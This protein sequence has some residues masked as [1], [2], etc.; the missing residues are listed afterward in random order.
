MDSNKLCFGIDFGTTNSCISI[1]H[2]NEPI[3]IEDFEGS[4]I[5]PTVIE[6]QD[7]KKIIGKEAYNRKEIFE[8]M[9]IDTSTIYEIKKL[10]GKKFSDLKEEEI[11]LIGYSLSSDDSDKIIL[12]NKYYVEEIITH[13]FMSFKHFSNEFLSKKFKQDLNISNAIITV[14]ARFNDNQREV[15]KMCAT[16]AGFNVIRL[17]NEPTSA[18]LAYG[19]GFVNKN[20]EKKIVVFDLGGGTLDISILNIFDNNYEV[21]G[22]SGNSSLGGS[23]FDIKIME[24]CIKKFIENNKLKHEEVTENIS[25]KSLQK[26]KYLS[27]KAKISLSDNLHTKII[28][29]DFYDNLNL[30]IKLSREEFNTICKDLISLMLKPMNELLIMCELEKTD[31]DEIIMVGGMTKMPIVRQNVELFFNNKELNDSIDPD[32]VVSIGSALYG[33]M[34]ISEENIED[35]LLLIDRTSLSIGLETSGGIMDILIPRGSIIPIKKV[36][37]YTTDTDFMENITIK[38]FEGERKFTKDNF[39]IGEFVL[40]GIEKKKRGIPEIQ[41]TFFID[42]NGIIKIKAEDL[43]NTLNKKT[44]QINGNKQNLNQEQIDK[45]IESAKMMDSIDR[46]DKMKKQ[47]YHLLIDNSKKIL[48]NIQNENLKADDETKQTIIKNVSEVLEWIQNTKYDEIDV[49]KY[50]ELIN[51][52]NLNY[53]IF[54]IHNEPI[55]QLK[56]SNENEDVGV[57][58]YE[59]EE[60]IKKYPEQVEY[61]RNIIFEYSKYKN[62]FEIL[63]MEE[64]SQEQIDSIK[65]LLKLISE[66]IEYSDNFLVNFFISK[67]LYDEFVSSNCNKI[68]EMDVYFKEELDKYEMKWNTLYKLDQLLNVTEQQLLDKLESLEEIPENEEEMENINNKLSIILEY[69]KQIYSIKNKY[70]EYNE[71]E[72][73]KIFMIVSNL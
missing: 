33:H 17:L 63:Q 16:N 60:Y 66:L 7:N 24:Y 1:W 71:E 12:L 50:K 41:I 68:Y 31:I 27:E 20:E 15:I 46:V 51:N 49:D 29:N 9:D 26:L 34:L 45:I 32:N 10:I 11:N 73:L 5:I 70:I 13:L 21:L 37:K 38:I 39:L 48:E 43:N 25:E 64:N 22:S 42:H 55:I 58:I 62:H 40:T 35:K 23:N 57:K 18:S 36:K 69:Q 61:V 6:L 56:E 52:F 65:N 67:A 2:N 72:L 4:N 53:S 28:I 47:S 19:V 54:L 30:E 8:K 59:D 44:I 3:I 14:P